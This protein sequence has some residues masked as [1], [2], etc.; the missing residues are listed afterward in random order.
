MTPAE[1]DAVWK[2]IRERY[3]VNPD[4]LARPRTD[5]REP[6]TTSEELTVVGPTAAPD[7]GGDDW[8]S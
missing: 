5:A 1:H 4:A 2:R 7:P 8:R 3:A 6:R